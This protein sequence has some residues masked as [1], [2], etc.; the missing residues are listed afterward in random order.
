MD[1]VQADKYE[2]KSSQLGNKL[3]RL[4][5]S[6]CCQICG[7]FFNN[8]HMLDCGHSFCSL[9]ILRHFDKN[10]NKT[11]TVN[12]CPSCNITCESS[13]LKPNRNLCTIVTNFQS[14]RSLLISVVNN[15]DSNVASIST[16][17]SIPTN[18]NPSLSSKHTIP[19]RKLPQKV[20]HKYP[21][22]KMKKELLSLCTSCGSSGMYV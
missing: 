4:E 12:K 19:I 22:D 5:E 17:E 14:S 2:W 18:S 11:H 20:F 21:K 1:D 3:G 13:Q 10:I 9:C 16:N 8:P 15:P 7:D 6:L